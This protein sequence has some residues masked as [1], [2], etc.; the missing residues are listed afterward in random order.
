VA[1]RA[2]ATPARS[3][4]ERDQGLIWL[5]RWGGDACDTVIRVCDN[6]DELY[7][8]TPEAVAHARRACAE[9]AARAGAAGT[10]VESVRLAV[11]EA[12]T[13]AV[14]HGYPEAA[15]EVSVVAAVATGELWVL[16][17]DRGR[18]H[19]TPS[20]TPGL[21]WGLALIAEATEEFVIIE[22]SGGG[23]EVRMR[24]AF[25]GDPGQ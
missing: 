17:T 5:W 15:G 23:T 1:L 9:F 16:I 22:R 20:P 12:V 6:L 8:A 3:C 21:G 7:P 2:D 10:T 24:F 4:G 19:Q 13:N 18:G 25:P 11:S 14:I